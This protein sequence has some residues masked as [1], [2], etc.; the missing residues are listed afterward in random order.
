MPSSA[1]LYHIILSNLYVNAAPGNGF[2]DNLKITDYGQDLVTT[3]AGLT[4]A[5]SEAKSRGNFRFREIINQISIVCNAYLSLQPSSTSNPYAPYTISDATYKTE[6][7][8]FQFWLIIEHGDASL[9]TADEYNAGQFLTG[10]ACLQRCIA[11]A[12]L[13]D[14]FREWDIFDPTETTTLGASPTGY[15]STTSV[16]R[17]GDRIYIAANFEIGPYA[18]SLSNA[19]AAINVTKVIF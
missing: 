18:S 3:P 15:G 2:V 7:T 11:R 17:Y 9:V 16:I 4:L 6:A 5:L 13:L 10:A 19:N 1:T 12:F 14:A 8:V